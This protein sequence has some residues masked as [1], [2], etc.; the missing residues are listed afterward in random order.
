MAGVARAVGSRPG[1]ERI[2]HV[3]DNLGRPE[4]GLSI[5]HVAGTNGKGSV[6][7][8]ISSVLT[9]AGYSTGLYTSPHLVQYQE[10]FLTDGGG[11]RT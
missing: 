3:L 9:A 7:T 4:K 11:S 8:F 5:I 10:R 2:N 1:L 6:A